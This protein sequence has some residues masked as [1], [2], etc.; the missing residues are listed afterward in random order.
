MSEMSTFE[1]VRE[2]ASRLEFIRLMEQHARFEG[3]RE[4]VPGLR[5]ARATQPTDRVTGVFRPSLCVVAQ[6][7]KDIYLGENV[8][9]YDSEHYLVA[10]V[11]MPIT[12]KV[13]EASLSKPYLSIRLELDPILVGSVMVEAGLPS[14]QKHI[15]AKAVFIS[16]LGPDLIDATVRMLRILDSP[17][18]VRSL[19][20]LIKREIIYRL[21]TGDQGDR[22]RHLPMLGAHTHRVIQAV[23]RLRNEF[24]QPLSIESLARELGMSSSGFHHHF[25]SVM[26][27]SPLQF[28][29]LIRLQEARQLMLAEN[30][31][32]SSAGYRVGYEDPSHFSRDYKR[33]F[34]EAPMRDVARLRELVAAD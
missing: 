22:L 8:Y 5:L 23:E 33:Q 7:A 6:G 17:S 27:M 32:A 3:S 15:E 12:G 28:Q 30:L 11:E 31:D 34:G 4:I 13:V 1:E 10:S 21:L 16:H 29:K 9:R 26:D 2:E 19:L 18:E 24:D 14:P 25:K 20:P